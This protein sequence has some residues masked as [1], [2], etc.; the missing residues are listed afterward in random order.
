MMDAEV[1]PAFEDEK[2]ET[3]ISPIPTS[4]KPMSE[5]SH[6]RVHNVASAEYVK[7]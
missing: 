5:Y 6:E 2:V 1:A 4:I 3:E 7:P